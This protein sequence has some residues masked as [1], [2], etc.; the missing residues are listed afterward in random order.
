MNYNKI[1]KVNPKE[2]KL[3]T[4]QKA[5]DKCNGGTS[6]Y[7]TRCQYAKNADACPLIKAHAARRDY[8]RK[9]NLPIERW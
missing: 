4:I 6:C 8:C 9:N 1:L 2:I 3:Q 7:K 5:I